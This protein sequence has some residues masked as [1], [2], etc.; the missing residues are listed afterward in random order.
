MGQNFTRIL[1]TGFLFLAVAACSSHAGPV[2]PAG[3]SGAAFAQ[4]SARKATVPQVGGVYNGTVTER[5]QGRTVKAKLKITLKQSGAKFTGIF[6][7][8][9]KTIQDQFPIIK[10]SVLSL[11]G[12]TSLHFVIEGIPGRNAK[13]VATLVG[14]ALKG[15]AR[16][17]ARHGPAV[18]FQFSATKA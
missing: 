1:L 9:L 11:H 4:G 10:G 8:I 12:K 6:D 18:R 2:L 15:K 5:S 17:S 7:M 14:K 16:V 3:A 13:A